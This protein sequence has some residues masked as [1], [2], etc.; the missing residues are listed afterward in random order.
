VTL[1]V[2]RL[3]AGSAVGVSSGPEPAEPEQLP[4]GRKPT[5]GL[6]G[7][8]GEK[9]TPEI[10]RQFRGQPNLEL[11]VPVLAPGRGARH[12]RAIQAKDAPVFAQS[13]GLAQVYTEIRGELLRFLVARLG[14]PMAAED[15][16][17]DLWL[18]LQSVD[19]GPVANSRAYLYR[20]A[21][22][23][24]LDFVRA[25]QRG[26]ARDRQWASVHGAP[27][28]E[29][30]DPSPNAEADLLARE[31]AEILASA[32]AALPE[33]AGRAF[34]LH[35]LEGLSHAEVAERLGISRSGVEKHIAVAMAH[36]RR[37]MKG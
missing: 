6:R 14:D 7:N 11:R 29:P 13:S 32:I 12:T 10:G 30:V 27:G 37:A 28:Q 15:V 5:G 36:L 22:N 21:Q 34:R 18:R 3:G 25:R 4:T 33:A 31:E 16:L 26:A 1:G 23:I 20:A 24:A 17:Q 9:R 2:N 35:K 19:S 8:G